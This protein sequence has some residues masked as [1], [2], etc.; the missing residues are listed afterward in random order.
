MHYIIILF[1]KD[2]KSPA[3]PA[4]ERPEKNRPT[5]IRGKARALYSFRA[6]NR[7]FLYKLRYFNINNI[8]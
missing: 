8:L 1:I 3:K 2:V 6:Q 5:K 7:R 4:I